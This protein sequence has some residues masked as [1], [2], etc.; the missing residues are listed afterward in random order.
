MQ[1]WNL[2]YQSSSLQADQELRLEGPGRQR[3]AEPL[4][5]L[6]HDFERQ[7]LVHRHPTAEPGLAPEPS[8]DEPDPGG[9]FS[10]DISDLEGYDE[11]ATTWPY[12]DVNVNENTIP[13]SRAGDAMED[14]PDGEGWTELEERLATLGSET[15]EESGARTGNFWN[16]RAGL[17]WYPLGHGWSGRGKRP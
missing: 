10:G 1:N 14:G 3:R 11:P 5:R 12:M 15:D 2:Y 6:D 8:H 4:H 9:T 13:I 16:V 17:S 7:R